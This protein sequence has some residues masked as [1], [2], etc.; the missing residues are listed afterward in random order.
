MKVVQTAFG[1]IALLACQASQAGPLVFTFDD[2]PAG[3][4]LSYYAITYGVKFFDTTSVVV[5]HI[6]SP[7][8]PPHSGSNVLV[9]DRNVDVHGYFTLLE[10]N[11]HT[12]FLRAFSVGGYFS[13]EYGTVLEMQGFGPGGYPPIVTTLI[14]ASDQAWANVYV[15]VS[16]PP[17][18]IYA[19]GIREISAGGLDHFCVDDVTV[20]LVPEPSSL[21]ALALG[22]APVGIAAARRKR[23]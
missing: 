10:V 7:W 6:G 17:A 18:Q 13:T 4:G 12:E 8:G 2:I 1:V 15:E 16:A 19:V 3:Y 14:G 5:D 20:N 22:L 11:P 9:K 23:R 21:S